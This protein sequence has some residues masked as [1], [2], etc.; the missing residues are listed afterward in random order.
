MRTDASARTV[1]TRRALAAGVVAAAICGTALTAA[2]AYADGTAGQ[3]GIGRGAVDSLDHGSFDVPVWTDATDAAVTSVT[4]KVLD[5]GQTVATRSLVDGGYAW[6]LGSGDQLKLTE[7]GGTLPRLGRYDVEIT[8]TDSKGDTLTRAE[9]GA[10]D[11]TLIPLFAAATGTN[12][13]VTGPTGGVSLEPAVVDADH[14][15]ETVG[16]TLL[17]QQPGSRDLVPLAGRTVTVAMGPTW[18]EVDRTAVTDVDGRFSTTFAV[19]QGLS[20]TARYTESSD[21]ADG[22]ASTPERTPEYHSSAVAITATADVR[23]VLPGQNVT[24]SGEVHSTLSA[25]SPGL[26]GVPVVG[27]FEGGGGLEVHTVTDATGHFTLTLPGDPESGG[28]W[29]AYVSQPFR[30]GSVSGVVVIPDESLFTSVASAVSA[31]DVVTVSGKLLRTYHRGAS[32]YGQ[33]VGLWYSPDGRTGWKGLAGVNLTSS[34]G[35][36]KITANGYLDGY[37]QVRHATSDQLVASNGPIVHLTRTNTRIFQMY[38]N[39]ARAK[40]NSTLT[41]TGNLKQDVGNVWKP[42]GGQYVELYFQPKGSTKWSYLGYSHTDSTGHAKFTSKAVQ[43]GRWLIQYFG[44]G[45]HFESDAAAVYVDV[46]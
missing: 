8:A 19:P 34:D 36:F 27:S 38:A 32:T 20:F 44:D 4:M 16:G 42:F 30:S 25:T 26:A 23:R 31:D 18:N 17:G 35:S 24:I 9:P 29:T 43:D 10:L 46:V 28:V 14:T 12:G 33:N 37:Y 6:S 39:T 22:Q 15:S 3:I 2:P 45:T 41:L 11:F 5:G 1:R 40:K 13:P 21:A 7:D